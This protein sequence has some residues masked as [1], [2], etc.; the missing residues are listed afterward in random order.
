MPS[1][2]T[3]ANVYSRGVD[4]AELSAQFE[5]ELQSLRARED[6]L[7]C[8]HRIRGRSL[9]KGEPFQR[10]DPVDPSR[11]VGLSFAADREVVGEAVADARRALPGWRRTPIAERIA[12]LQRTVEAITARSVQLAALLSFE[13]GKTRADALAEVGECRAIVELSCEQ[14]AAANGF[15]VPLKAPSSNSRAEVVLLPYGVFGVIAPFNF[16]LAIPFGMVVAAL[17]TGNTVVFKPSALTPASG[18]A[19]MDLFEDIGLPPGVLNTVQGGS[20]TGLHLAGSGVDG[21]AFTG[22]ADVGLGIA[23][24][25]HQPPFIRPVIAEMGGKNPAIVTDA[26]GDLEAAARA[27]ARSAFGMSGQKCNACS[28]AI[29]TEAIYEEFVDRLCAITETLKIGD[30]IDAASFTGPV[31]SDDSRQRFDNTVEQV[32]RDG[33][34]RTGGRSSSVGGYFVDCTVVDGLPAGHPLL[35]EELFLP[36]LSVT[37]VASL[38]EALAE[39]NAIRYGLSAG[40]FSDD[41]AEQERFLDEIEA[42]IVFINNPGGATTGVWPGSQTMSGWKGSGSSGKGGFGPW[43]LQQFAREQ[44]RTTVFKS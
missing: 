32:R 30:P 44:S 2:I 4:D 27:V 22:S 40:I 39:A 5:A 26:A 16:P 38:D 15:L 29:V 9:T 18:A 14:M 35:R 41:L 24:Q 3:Y 8:T 23:A 36:V 10:V 21:I 43:Y 42:G 19:F 11:I 1:A 13:V 31:I 33:A 34:L 25:L 28:R 17:I 37:K 12:I 20:A 6:P 7:T